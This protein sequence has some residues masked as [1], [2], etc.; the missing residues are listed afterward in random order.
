MIAYTNY[1]ID[2]RVI[3]AAEAAVDG[4]FDV[5]FIALR[6]GDQPREEMVRGVHVFRVAQE[7]YRAR[8]RAGYVSAYPRS[9]CAASRCPRG[10]S[11]RAAIA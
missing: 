1:E 2:P 8:A 7:R 5:D 4:G 3:R 11:S 10:C 9:S 6:R